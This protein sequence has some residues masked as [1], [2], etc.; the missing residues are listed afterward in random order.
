MSLTY[1]FYNSVNNDRTYNAEQLSSVFDGVIN[2]GIYM[3][4]GGKMMVK[5]NTGLTVK[6]S[7]GRAWF[8]HT[9]SYNDSDLNITLD[10]ADPLL[11]RIDAVVLEINRSTEVRANSF[12]IIKG[13]AA[14]N[15]SR[16]TLTN[17][18]NVKQ[19]PLA[20]IS[21]DAGTTE[22]SQAKIT[23]MIG[24]SA[25]PYVKGIIENISI[26]DMIAQWEAEFNEWMASLDA[27][28]S[29]DVAANLQGEINTINATLPNKVNKNG[30]T[31]SGN[32]SLPNSRL[33][34]ATVAA[35]G[36]IT[37]T[38]GNIEATN[39]YIN[40]KTTTQPSTTNSD[41]IASTKFVKTESATKQNKITYSTT[42]LTPGVSSLATGDIYVVYDPQ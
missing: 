3:S 19:Y 38:N 36:N 31:M 8:N 20:Y 26:N 32:L 1:G 17:T 42:D 16:P 7:S 40:G 21:I 4:V 22:I 34:A 9:W 6:I 23:N 2:D 37:S 39:G 15:P 30:D 25:T 27:A 11:N 14:T 29:G 24:T 10:S 5:S 13:T 33:S 12:K 18:T 28:L 35:S 41:L